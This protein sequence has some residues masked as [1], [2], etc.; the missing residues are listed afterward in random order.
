VFPAKAAKR[1]DWGGEP[2]G[3][4][5]IARHHPWGNTARA[6]GAEAT[7]F[8]DRANESLRSGY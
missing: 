6:K 5:A 2:K 1:S 7:A 8:S 4:V 3:A